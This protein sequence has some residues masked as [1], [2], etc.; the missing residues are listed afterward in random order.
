MRIIKDLPYHHIEDKFYDKK[1]PIGLL[2]ETLKSACT[3]EETFINCIVNINTWDY[4]KI[5]LWA[6]EDILN[7]IDEILNQYKQN[8]NE[9]K[10]IS[11]DNAIK[12]L[13]FIKLL[14][15][16]TFHKDIF[17]SFDALEDIFK[18]TFSLEVKNYIIEIYMLFS[19]VKKSMLDNFDTFTDHCYFVIPLRPLMVEYILEHVS[20]E[21]TTRVTELDKILI[22]I[23]RDGKKAIVTNNNQNQNIKNINENQIRNLFKNVFA[24]ANN[25]NFTDIKNQL[26]SCFNNGN[27]QTKFSKEEENLLHTILNFFLIS[28]NFSILKVQTNPEENL[29]NLSK[30][31]LNMINLIIF[32]TQKKRKPPIISEYYI[33]KYLKDVLAII[34]SRHQLELK[35]VYLL[36]TIGFVTYFDGYENILFQNGLFHSILSDMTSPKFDSTPNDLEVLSLEESRDHNFFN[37]ILLF[38]YKTSSFKEIPVHFLNKVLELPRDNIYPYRIDNVIFSLKKKELGRDNSK[39]VSDSKINIRIEQFLG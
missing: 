7:F 16:N 12:L 20:K 19:E 10:D 4:Q 11:I 15:M 13:K 6:F 28:T 35:S 1:S 38:L 27:T 9:R 17:A 25:V 8:L 39:R 32:S 21:D 3:I 37:A 33:E 30:F 24:N 22:Q 34:T 23:L 26:E 29:K 14:V 36:A 18:Q 31:T 2:I 5:S